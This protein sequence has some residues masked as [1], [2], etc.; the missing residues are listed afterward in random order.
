MI[1]FVKCMWIWGLCAENEAE[2]LDSF[3]NATVF[4]GCLIFV[5]KLKK[6]H[7]DLSYLSNYVLPICYSRKKSISVAS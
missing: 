7:Q 6:F 2:N 1:L 5:I 4:E 3:L